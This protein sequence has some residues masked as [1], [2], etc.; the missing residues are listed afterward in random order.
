MLKMNEENY[1][2]YSCRYLESKGNNE[3][4]TFHYY[5][6]GRNFYDASRNAVS[7]L[8]QELLFEKLVI[9]EEF[10]LSIKSI[11]IK[12]NGKWFRINE[13]DNKAEK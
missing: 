9:P 12:N 5:T 3:L 6:T 4:L 10:Y 8:A 7:A 2:D 11:E 13:Q 1:K